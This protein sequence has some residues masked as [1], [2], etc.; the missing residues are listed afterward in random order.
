MTAALAQPMAVAERPITMTGPSIP[1]IFADIKLQTRRLLRPAPDKNQLY[2]WRDAARVKWHEGQG[3]WAAYSRGLTRVSEWFACPYGAPGDRLWVRETHASFMVGEGKDRPV[4]QCVA[5]R[6][7]CDADGGFDYVNGRGEVMRLKVTKW[8]PAIFMP[9]WASRLTLELVEVRAQRV[10]DITEADAIAEGVR[11]LPLQAGESGAWWTYD[12][13]A[14]AAMHGRDPVAAYR[15][16]WDALNG[17]RRRREYLEVGDPGYTAD[18]PWRTV[19]D[20]SAAWAANPWVWAL[21]FRRVP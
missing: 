4:P 9:R 14:G 13:T 11:E 7:T 5:Y 19:V 21:T 15:K 3:A 1:A 8:T 17:K 12:V 10:K 18:R 2:G 16:A 20:T 6:A